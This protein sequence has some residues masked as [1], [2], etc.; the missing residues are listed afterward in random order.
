MR[1]AVGLL[2]GHP[3]IL[4]VDDEPDVRE[5]IL[6][7]LQGA[8]SHARVLSA[9]SAEEGLETLARHHVDLVLCDYRLPGMDGLRFLQ[10]AHRL[11]PHAPRILITGHTQLEV[12]A[13]AVNAARIEAVIT[14]PLDAE[15][16]IAQV[17]AAL[18][19][20]S[21]GRYVRDA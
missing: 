4:L 11:A 3:T 7:V 15:G 10:E 16:L 20:Q 14:K 1:R 2:A 9:G 12:A 13:Q 18:R 8:V 19:L 21:T 5:S 6:D 17:Q